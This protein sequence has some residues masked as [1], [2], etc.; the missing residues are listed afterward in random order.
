MRCSR[1]PGVARA[2]CVPGLLLAAGVTL[3]ACSSTTTR[4][5]KDPRH[6]EEVGGMPISVRRP[7]WLRVTRSLVTYGAPVE[8]RKVS[9]DDPSGGTA[10]SSWPGTGQIPSPGG[11]SSSGTPNAQ[12]RAAAA[13]R[14]RASGAPD[15]IRYQTV[16]TVCEITPE[17]IS[18]PELYA[19]DFKRPLI[20]SIDASIDWPSRA[21]KDA[22]KLD[23]IDFQYPTKIGATV[24]DNTLKQL[25][26]L[27][28]DALDLFGVSISETVASDLVPLQ[29]RIVSVEFYSLAR[30]TC[31][32]VRRLR[33]PESTCACVPLPEIAPCG[34]PAPPAQMDAS[35]ADGP[36]A[37]R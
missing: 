22:D 1:I 12:Q 7:R 33:I 4:R 31:H 35:S 27:V 19:V 29:R 32:L 15:V 9:K 21:T 30:G 14:A 17:I 13:R 11:P 37:R 5:V 6:L 3:L 25:K 18:V 8:Y 28:P 23:P 24:T 36:T 16:Q 20:G 26:D 10:D 2:L 34:P